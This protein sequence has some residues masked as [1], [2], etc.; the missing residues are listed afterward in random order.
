MSTTTQRQ[1]VDTAKPT[2]KTFV[3]FFLVILDGITS[4]LALP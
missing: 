3:I 4:F 2:D 1:R